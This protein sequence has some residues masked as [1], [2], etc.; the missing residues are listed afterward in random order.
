MYT[1]EQGDEYNLAEVEKEY[2]SSYN[3]A[4]ITNIV[5]PSAM[6]GAGEGARKSGNDCLLELDNGNIELG[7][8]V[9]HVF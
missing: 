9:K 5:H 3:R 2:V 8:N 1:A 4:I 6:R 7:T